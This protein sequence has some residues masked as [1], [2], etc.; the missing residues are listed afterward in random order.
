MLFQGHVYFIDN[1][2]SEM[3]L[4]DEERQFFDLVDEATAVV[5]GRPD[6]LIGLVDPSGHLWFTSKDNAKGQAY[7]AVKDGSNYS[8]RVIQEARLSDQNIGRCILYEK[9][10]LWYGGDRITRYDLNQSL[11]PEIAQ[12]QISKVIYGGDS[13]L[14]ASPYAQSDVQLPHRKNAL[15]FV[16]GNTSF[17]GTKPN[18]FQYKLDGYDDEWSSW[19]GEIQ[20]DY[21]SLPAGRY[22]MQVR[23]KNVFDRVSKSASFPFEISPPWHR[24]WWAYLLYIAMGLAGALL[25]ARVR[26][27]QLRREKIVLQNLVATRTS[28]L[29]LSNDKLHKQKVKLQSQAEKLREVDQMKSRLFA[30]IS[31]EFRTPLTLIKGPLDQ[32]NRFPQSALSSTNREMMSRNADRLLRLVNQLLD[33]SKLDA[34]SLPINVSEGNMYQHIRTAASAFSSLAAER[35]LDFQIK[36]PPLTFWASYDRDHLEKII[37][38]LVSNAFKFT[39]N[40][41]SIKIAADYAGGHVQV[42]VQDTGI[43]ISA[44]DQVRVFDRFHQVDDSTIRQEEGSGI[45]LS[46][47]K[48]L[49]ELMSG[50]I[51]L[52]SELGVGSTFLVRLPIVQILAPISSKEKLLQQ[53]AAT[54]PS[55][56]ETMSAMDARG[57]DSVLIVE[58]NQDMRQFIASHLRDT[59]HIIEATTG[60]EGLSQALAVVPDLIVT[61]LMM[62]E[63]DGL[64]LCELLKSDERSSHIP[65]IMLTAKAGMENKLIGL[66]TGADVYLTKPFDARELQV[67]VKNLIEQRNRL[68]QRFYK[69][70]RFDP[71]KIDLPTVDQQFLQKVMDLLEARFSDPEFA[72]A[73]MQKE[74]GMSKTQLHRKF[75]ALTD[76]A[77]GQFLRLFRIKRAAQ[78]LEKGHAISDT[79][80]DCG[81]N[82]VSYFSKCF[83]DVHGTSPSEFVSKNYH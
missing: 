24:T 57:K 15:R 71:R 8:T 25:I 35:N 7:I 53:V 14:L 17:Q 58:D 30:N 81:F 2:N 42:E 27:R 22:S 74:L 68:R 55:Q 9:D 75:R 60:P 66:E 45:G 38:N 78:I 64:Q 70:D 52:E 76:Q 73:N 5:A 19:S 46:L 63:M 6:L 83:K 50:T 10:V 11:M 72:A 56:T 36:I 18:Y 3:Y 26:G 20:K 79:A 12:A 43:G 82:S 16:F 49:V 47:V 80:Y 67:H 44:Q 29:Q 21:T 40:D 48:E 4:F 62:P 41:G 1:V 34:G 51:H 61:D 37:Y 77:P 39:P 33:L 69:N 32:L 54:L 59:H 23:S 13:T 65:I 28:E 31:H